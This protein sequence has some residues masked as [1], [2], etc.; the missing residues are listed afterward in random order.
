MNLYLKLLVWIQN[1]R[2]EIYKDN[3]KKRFI[4]RGRVG[5]MVTEYNKIKFDKIE[6][7]EASRHQFELGSIVLD[8][9]FE[10]LDNLTFE[11]IEE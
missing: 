5:T 8:S 2:N 9:K 4:F 11:Q 10:L 1:T 7:D 6:M 3:S